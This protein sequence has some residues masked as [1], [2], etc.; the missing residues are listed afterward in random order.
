MELLELARRGSTRIMV[1]RWVK[2]MVHPDRLGDAKLIGA[3]LD[4]FARKSADSF[5]AQIRALLARTDAAPLL[6]RIACPA[7]VLCGREDSWSPLARHEEMA[8]MIPGG[9]LAVIDH[10]GHMSPMERPEAVASALG[11]WLHRV[12]TREH[13]SAGAPAIADS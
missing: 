6:P 1:E 11:E 8:A 12:D 13:S 4:M 7:L 3:I 10:C 5:A 2:G 9:R